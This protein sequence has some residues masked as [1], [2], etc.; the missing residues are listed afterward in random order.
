VIAGAG[1]AATVDT[2]VLV[3]TNELS[4]VVVETIVDGSGL[5]IVTVNG[6]G[7]AEE[8]NVDT[9]ELVTVC[10]VVDTAV[11]VDMNVVV[12][13]VV[14]AAAV[15]APYPKPSA[16]V[17]TALALVGLGPSPNRLNSPPNCGSGA[18]IASAATV[19]A[20][21]QKLEIFIFNLIWMSSVLEP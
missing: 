3:T 10:L 1:V 18:G 9:A 5:V 4:I 17:F 7:Y 19:A 21:T 8:V 14:D 15:P 11:T 6:V 2:N 16:F 12:I 13:V 20:S